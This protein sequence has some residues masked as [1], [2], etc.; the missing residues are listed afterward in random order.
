MVSAGP[1]SSPLRSLTSS[2]NIS[3]QQNPQSSD[4]HAVLPQ[5]NVLGSVLRD[6]YIEDFHTTPHNQTTQP[7]QSSQRDHRGLIINYNAHGIHSNHG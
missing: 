6:I 5:G 3:S 4:M 7:S 2:L 1:H